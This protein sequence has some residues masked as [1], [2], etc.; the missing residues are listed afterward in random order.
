MLRVSRPIRRWRL[1]GTWGRRGRSAW[2]SAVGV[3]GGADEFDA[4]RRGP[5]KPTEPAAPE[6]TTLSPFLIRPM[7][8]MPCRRRQRRGRKPVGSAVPLTKYAVMPGP[9]QH[10]AYATR[11]RVWLGSPDT[12]NN[13]RWS[14]SRPPLGVLFTRQHRAPHGRRPTWSTT[15]TRHTPHATHVLRS[16]LVAWPTQYS[17][18]PSVPYT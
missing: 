5:T 2:R 7:S 10:G 18:H 1:R 11:E 17:C 9:N 8:N 6:I 14:T 3:S 15:T 12:P 16:S 4:S 13:P